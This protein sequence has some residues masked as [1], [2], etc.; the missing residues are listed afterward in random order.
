MYGLV[1]LLSLFILLCVV[2]E[3]R[4]CL[5]KGVVYHIDYDE[6]RVGIILNVISYFIFIL[7]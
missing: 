6:T 7:F 2:M 4:K 5:L 1:Q 3:M